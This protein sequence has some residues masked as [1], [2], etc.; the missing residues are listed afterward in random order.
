[1]HFESDFGCSLAPEL[2]SS[3][4]FAL[5]HSSTIVLNPGNLPLLNLLNINLL[6]RVTSND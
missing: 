5:T 1:M 4:L 2:G 3:L 6:F